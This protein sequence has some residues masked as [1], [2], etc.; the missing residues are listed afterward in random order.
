M[1]SSLISV[2]GFKLT[3]GHLVFAA[4]GAVL[5]IVLA[6]LF[7][8]FRRSAKEDPGSKARAKSRAASDDAFLKGITHL[9]ADHTDKAIEEFSKAVTL[10]SDTVETYVVLGNLFRQKGE[11]ERAVRIRQNI[12]ARPNLNPATRQQALYDLGLDYKKGGLYN[13]AAEAFGE[14]LSANPQHVEALGQV[15][16]LYE[17]MRDWQNAFESL[18]QLD[19]LTKDN[20]RPILAHYKTERGK[21]LME[22]GDLEKAEDFF[23]QAISVYKQCLDPYLHLGDLELARGRHKK[24]LNIWR[25]AVR[26]S[27]NNAHLPLGRV[28]SA[29][30][31]LGVAAVEHFLKEINPKEAEMATLLSL[32]VYHK[33][34]ERED[35]SLEFLDL[36]VAKTPDHLGAHRLRGEILLNRGAGPQTLKAYG[37]LL[38]QIDGEW[39]AYQCGQCGLISPQLTW[40]CPRCLKWDTMSPVGPAR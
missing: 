36:A 16:S 30:D 8:L 6:A 12:I 4:L 25:K 23:N 9:M 34:H 35:A 39:S 38:A 5:V 19:K 27:N 37:E 29:E 26:L 1:D 20:S 21:E 32:A 40:K 2:F 3:T 7:G 11:I 18:K 31:E 22:E 17:E 33:K 24:A 14:L 10:N 13:R 15:V 28:L